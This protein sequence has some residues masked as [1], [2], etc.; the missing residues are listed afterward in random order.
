LKT[1]LRNYGR[2]WS[3][4]ILLRFFML[5]AD[6]ACAQVKPFLFTINDNNRR[7]NIRL[8]SAVRMAFRVTDRIPK[9]RGFPTNITL[10]NR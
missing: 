10:Q 3:N 1:Q 6:T 2:A 5:V 8:P 4:I 9:L 7:M